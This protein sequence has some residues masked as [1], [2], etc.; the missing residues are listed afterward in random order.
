MVRIDQTTLILAPMLAGLIMSSLGVFAGCAFIAVWNAVSFGFEYSTLYFVYKA[1]PKLALPRQAAASE[2]I[3]GSNG[4]E[5]V[6]SE[7]TQ[8][9]SASEHSPLLSARISTR[10]HRFTSGWRAYINSSF[11]LAG[12]AMALTYLTVLSVTDGV[13]TG[14]AYSQVRFI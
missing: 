3:G 7:P 11:A 14:F 8:A 5:L 2:P 1:T 13:M 9:S 6:S 10:L 4:L 12:L